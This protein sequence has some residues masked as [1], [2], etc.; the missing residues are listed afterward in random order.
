MTAILIPS[1]LLSAM[2]ACTCA[3]LSAVL[4][5]GDP[6]PMVAM[7]RLCGFLVSVA[8]VAVSMVAAAAFW[9]R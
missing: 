5:V 4:P 1:L 3:L 2:A 6:S 8:V 7:G 9:E